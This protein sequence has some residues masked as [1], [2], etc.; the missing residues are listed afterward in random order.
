MHVKFHLL[1]L[2]EDKVVYF[3]GVRLD[4]GLLFDFFTV[5]LFYV[6]SSD[7]EYPA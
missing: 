3:N 2:C 7:Y 5:V 4:G 6:T 1:T